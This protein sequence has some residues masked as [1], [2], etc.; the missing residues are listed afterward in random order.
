MQETISS[1]WKLTGLISCKGPDSCKAVK[2]GQGLW[3][4]YSGRKTDRFQAQHQPAGGNDRNQEGNS[5]Q[6]YFL[7]KKT[8]LYLCEGQLHGY[9]GYR[10][11]EGKCR[12]LT[13]YINRSGKNSRNV[14]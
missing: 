8:G 1:A 4:G 7:I 9:K 13:E 2:A 10:H 6:M 3:N 12:A 14:F 11:A 5:I